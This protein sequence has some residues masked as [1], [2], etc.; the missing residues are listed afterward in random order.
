MSI[1]TFDYYMYTI[2]MYLMHATLTCDVISGVGRPH[3]Q[4]DCGSAV[5]ANHMIY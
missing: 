5:E 3:N 2:H 1:L 4:I